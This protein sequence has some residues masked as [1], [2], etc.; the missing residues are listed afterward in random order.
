MSEIARRL[1][2]IDDDPS[3]RRSIGRQLKEAPLAATFAT[4]PEA[5]LRQVTDGEWDIVLCDIKMKPIDGLEVLA[6]IRATRPALPVIMLTGFVDDQLIERAL[7]LGA[8]D[9]LIKPV[10]REQLVA[11]LGRALAPRRQTPPPDILGADGG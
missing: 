2:V 9:V 11:A 1:L 10:R 7:A 3:V 5:A 6:R 4:D 8:R